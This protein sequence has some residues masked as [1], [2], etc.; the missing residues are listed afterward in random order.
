[1]TGNLHR[2]RGRRCEHV[3]N[4]FQLRIGICCEGRL[5]VLERNVL[6]F[7]NTSNFNRHEEQITRDRCVFLLLG[8]IQV[9]VHRHVAIG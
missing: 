9:V 3:G 1:M 6:E 4:T 7:H 8:E 2:H 5:V